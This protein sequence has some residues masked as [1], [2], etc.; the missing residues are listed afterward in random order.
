MNS[1]GGNQSC[2]LCPKLWSS[3]SIDDFLADYRH[4]S[5]SI[6]SFLSSLEV[7]KTAANRTNII[8]NTQISSRVQALTP[9]TFIQTHQSVSCIGDNQAM[10]A[11]S[12][13]AAP[14]DLKRARDI[15][16]LHSRSRQP[17]KKAVTTTE[18]Q[19]RIKNRE[20]QRRFREKKLRLELQ[21]NSMPVCTSPSQRFW[22]SP[23]GSK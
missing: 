16:Q 2:D 21:R 12:A 18:E 6:L 22:P 7:P 13:A 14:A 3:E 10:L 8:T 19:K 5:S 17:N 23:V 4:Y 11:I 9:S 1:Q 15:N 20:Y